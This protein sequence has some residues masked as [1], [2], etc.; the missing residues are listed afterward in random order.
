MQLPKAGDE[1]Q[2]DDS[3]RTYWKMAILFAAKRV[4]SCNGGFSESPC[5]KLW[6]TG[7]WITGR[8]RIAA[9]FHSIE[10]AGRSPQK[11]LTEWMPS[12]SN[13]AAI[14]RSAVL[15]ICEMRLSLT[16]STSPI[17]FMVRSLV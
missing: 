17:S 15:W 13:A 10:T 7:G 2:E 5:S 1:E 4:S 16:P 14:F 6:S 8:A 9:Q 11:A 12:N 3:P